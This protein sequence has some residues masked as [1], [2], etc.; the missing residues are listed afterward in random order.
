METGLEAEK[1]VTEAV[2]L[3][4]LMDPW[5]V[6]ATGRFAGQ[7]QG[8]QKRPRRQMNIDQ[9]AETVVRDR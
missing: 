6:E 7:G 2:S 4:R 8:A 1:V 3:Y 9:G 5:R